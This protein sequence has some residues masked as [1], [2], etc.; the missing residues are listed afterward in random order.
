M[1]SPL[2][3]VPLLLVLLLLLGAGAVGYRQARSDRL[4]HLPADP[5]SDVTNIGL[6]V[7][8]PAPEIAGKDCDG[9]VF[10][11]S[12]YRGKVVVLD[13]LVDR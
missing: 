2:R 7:G 8:I 6:P 10:R 4:V 12:D 11:L 5:M 1:R 9:K 3:P 13:C